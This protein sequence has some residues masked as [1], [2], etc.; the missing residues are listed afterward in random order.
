MKKPIL[1]T[2]C[3]S[4]FCLIQTSCAQQSQPIEKISSKEEILNII[5]LSCENDNQCKA[6]GF[7]DSPCGGYSSYLVYSETD[8]DVT[9]LKKMVNKYNALDKI[10]HQK[11]GIVGIC[12]HIPPPGT[13]CNANQCVST[14]N[15]QLKL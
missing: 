9:Q 6:I 14:S 12:R 2:L 8:T 1:N 15:H 10:K 13:Q 4:I 3:L 5:G 7:G 11:Q